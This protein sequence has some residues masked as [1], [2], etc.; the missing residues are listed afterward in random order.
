[1]KD[2]MGKVKEGS[3]LM[4]RTVAGEIRNPFELIGLFLI[5]GIFIAIGYGFL[6]SPISDIEFPSLVILSLAG[7][8]VLIPVEFGIIL[9][10]SKKELGVFSIKR[11]ITY[12]RSIPVKKILM[13][14]TCNS[15][16]DYFNL[17][18]G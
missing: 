3:K 10:Y 5:P 18:F 6:A 14:S 2:D 11:M 4:E 13:A 15:V 8:F 12:Q 7:L 16:F 1:M 17:C 9:Y